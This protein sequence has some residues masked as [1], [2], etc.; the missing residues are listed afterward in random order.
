MQEACQLT[1]NAVITQNDDYYV[2]AGTQL[3]H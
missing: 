1:A 3:S 2:E